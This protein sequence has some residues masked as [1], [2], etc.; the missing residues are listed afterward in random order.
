MPY[1]DPEARKKFD[2]KRKSDPKFIEQRRFIAA[3]KSVANKVKAVLYKGGKCQKCDYDRCYASLD[4]HHRDPTQKDGVWNKFKGRSW[5]KI[6]KELDKC[7]LLCAN[8]HREEHFNKDAAQ[9][10]IDYFKNRDIKYVKNGIL[11][12]YDEEI[13]YVK[14]MPIMN[15]ESS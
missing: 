8:C 11:V 9:H 5:A 4:F 12:N 13:N 10:M 15:I 6:K 7:D 2:E 1:K 3:A 14:E